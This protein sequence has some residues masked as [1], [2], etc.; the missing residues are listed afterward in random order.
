MKKTLALMAAPVLGSLVLAGCGVVNN[1]M[2]NAA[3]SGA[4][5]PPMI[6][7]VN[8]GSPGYI[9]DFNPWS[10]NVLFGAAWIYETLYAI[11]AQNGHQTPWLAT[12]YKWET[13]TKLVFTIRHGVKWSNGTPF[14]AKDVAFTFN[15]EKKFP[16][17]N[18]DGLWPALKSVTAV[19]N[20]V[21]FTFNHPDVPAFTF[22]ADTPI[23]P[24]SIWSKVKNPVTWPD[25]HPVGTGAYVLKS[26]T[27]QNYT[28]VKNPH[29]WQASKVAVK[30][31][32][33]PVV[34]QSGAT[35]ELELSEGDFTAANAF[36]PNLQKV[37]IDKDPKYRH[38]WFAPGGPSNLVMNLTEYPF[39]QVK[40]R[41]AMAYAINR[42]EVSS[43]GEYG[44]QPVANMT[45]LTLP[46]QKAFLD[47]S[48]KDPYHY[49]P[50]KAMKLLESMGLKKNSAGQLVGPH[51]PIVVTV[52]VPNSF[53]DWIE[54]A[55]IIRENLGKLGITVHVNTPSVSTWTSDLDTG[56][57][58]MSLTYG[59]NYYN[60]YFYY[61]YT[62]DGVNSAPI[63][64]VAT[65]NYERYNNPATNQ[66][67][68]EYDDATTLQQQKPII[69]K[70]QAIML[71]QVPVIPMF[72]NANWNEYDTRYYVGWPSASDP[73]CT[74]DY[75]WPDVEVEFTHLR[76]R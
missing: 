11:N 44:Y 10:P 25:T 68:A 62:L 3:N 8:P 6:L 34:P 72:Y 13:P 40:F 65:S 7:S 67:L 16:A 73:Y 75:T 12:S 61:F 53:S 2:V 47:S 74:P 58:S 36:V 1:A 55:Q 32:E 9:D 56:T 64:K 30:E 38:Y 63:G 54:D 14:T 28:L 35:A 37:Y 4:S 42:N 19:K 66:L 70:L 45:G 23:V 49:D 24:E 39:N 33:F 50:K 5:A 60:P 46:N 31:I 57:F 27:N 51:G 52:T 43:K 22:I 18:N 41:Q 17:L 21:V 71:Q 59:L 15:L 76:V 48:L 20:R 26:F 29:Y 69:D